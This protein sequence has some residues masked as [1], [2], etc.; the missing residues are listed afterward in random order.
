MTGRCREVFLARNKTI[1]SFQIGVKRLRNTAD[2][3]AG[4]F[5]AETNAAL[6]WLN[7]GNPFCQ[8]PQWGQDCSGRSERRDYGHNQQHGNTHHH[9]QEYP[10]FLTLPLGYIVGQHSMR[11]SHVTHLN[12]VVVIIHPDAVM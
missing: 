12:L 3:I 9:Q 5:G 7:A 10:V 6:L 11:A 8:L 2:L 4:K 1:Q